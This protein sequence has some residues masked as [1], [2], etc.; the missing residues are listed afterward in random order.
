MICEMLM[1][2]NQVLLM[3]VM[4]GRLSSMFKNLSEAS[5]DFKVLLSK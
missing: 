2:M 4:D 3:L 1:Q 5:N